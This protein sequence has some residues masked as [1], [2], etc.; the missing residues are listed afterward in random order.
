MMISPKTYIEQMKDATY[1][2]L[3]SERKA[4][5]KFI[6]AYEK[7][8]R[9][10]DRSGAEWQTHPT[11]DVRYQCYLEYCADLCSYMREKYN[12]EYVWGDKK[13]SE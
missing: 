1:E 6:D 9:K 8:E 10:G 2:E 3:I 5:I 4:L 12:E 11:P 7:K 13:L